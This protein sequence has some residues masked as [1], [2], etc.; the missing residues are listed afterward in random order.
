MY[1]LEILLH[2]E[3]QLVQRGIYRQH[4]AEPEEYGVP[5]GRRVHHGLGCQVAGR[6]APVVHHPRLPQ[7]VV[8]LWSDDPR[9]RIGPATWGKRHEQPH[10]TRRIVSALRGARGGKQR[11]GRRRAEK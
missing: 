11:Y 7:R 2:A 6:A 5:I 9:Q 8:E 4:G 10:R 3:R 1:R